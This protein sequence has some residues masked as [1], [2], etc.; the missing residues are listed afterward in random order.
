MNEYFDLIEDEDLDDTG[1]AHTWIYECPECHALF[2]SKAIPGRSISSWFGYH[3]N[4]GNCKVVDDKTS[5]AIEMRAMKCKCEPQINKVTSVKK[6]KELI[7]FNV[8]NV[9]TA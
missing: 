5:F 3:P 6:L 9:E 8:E 2:Q 7:K 4:D 1:K